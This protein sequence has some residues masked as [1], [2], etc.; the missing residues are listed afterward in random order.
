[1][2]RTSEEVGVECGEELRS[3]NVGDSCAHLIEVLV[4]VELGKDVVA[5]LGV[6]QMIAWISCAQDLRS[7][8]R[9][10]C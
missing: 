5:T 9:H 10:G 1:M 8:I 7:V 6:L 2:Q 3:H 4:V